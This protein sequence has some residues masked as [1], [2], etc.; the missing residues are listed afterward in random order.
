MPCG[1]GTGGDDAGVVAERREDLAPRSGQ[2]PAASLYHH[3]MPV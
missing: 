1:D 2:V 3:R